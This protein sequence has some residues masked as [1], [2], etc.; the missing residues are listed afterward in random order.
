MA[1]A[2]GYDMSGIHNERTL[3]SLERNYEE[4]GV[5]MPLERRP[6]LEVVGT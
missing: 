3:G 1:M 2:E 4:Y 5:V 6:G